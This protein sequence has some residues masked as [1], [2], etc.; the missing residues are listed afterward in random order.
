MNEKTESI[1]I[2]AYA[3]LNLGLRILGKRAD[4]YHELHTIFQQIDLHDT[5]R[6][7]LRSDGDIR[8]NSSSKA[9][10]ADASNLA[11]RAARLFFE[12]SGL[13]TGVDIRLEK[14]IPVGAGLGGGSSDAAAVLMGLNTLCE[15]PLARDH[16]LHLAQKLGADVPFFIY[17]GL[18]QAGGI[19]E[20]LQPLDTKLPVYFVV[21]SP[22]I[23]V[24]TAEA[25]AG[26]KISLTNSPG[27]IN[28]TQFIESLDFRV[29]R[30]HL[31]NDFETLIFSRFPDLGV[32]KEKLYGMGADYAGLSGSGCSLFGVFR[33]EQLA[34]D[35]VDKFLQLY[36][37][38]LAKPVQFGMREIALLAETAG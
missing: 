6:L 20:K 2:P 21:V 35:G 37:V 29:W 16:L 32:I 26:L 22:P 24:S 3:K 38:H 30:E 12:A 19:G 4:G 33:D 31:V 9:V 18:A 1:Q 14:R 27:N 23:F 11:F 7:R 8:L 17:G 34:R 5:I 13:N 28:L 10:P 25:F 36:S 15:T